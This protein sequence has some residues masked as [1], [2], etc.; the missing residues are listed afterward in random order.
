MRK[1]CEHVHGQYIIL[2]IQLHQSIGTVYVHIAQAKRCRFD[3][4]DGFSE[5]AAAACSEML[6]NLKSG[7]IR[8]NALPIYYLPVQ[9]EYTDT[10]LIGNLVTHN[11]VVI[12][13]E[14]SNCEGHQSDFSDERSNLPKVI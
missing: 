2:H 9:L 8:I 1:S 14:N 3:H 11:L 6:I 5:Q 10:I 12:S 7:A 4:T 13:C